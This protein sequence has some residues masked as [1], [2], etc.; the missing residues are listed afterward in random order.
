MVFRSAEALFTGSQ[1]ARID[2]K[3]RIAAPAEFRRALDT[4]RCNG[5]YC[6][7]AL[8][9]AHLDC[10]GPDFIERL[11]AMIGALEPYDCDRA[12]LEEALIGRARL[13]PLDA[14]GRFILPQPLKDYAGLSE[15]VFFIGLGG[16]FQIRDGEGAEAH[17]KAV[18]TRAAAASHKLK[19]PLVH[20]LRKE[21]ER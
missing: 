10:G 8:D 17:M 1:T 13:V 14:D 9:S 18:A 12:D 7:P 16:R 4:K 2:A 19:N 3:G 11:Q 6:T 21:D 5:F 20:S 15:S